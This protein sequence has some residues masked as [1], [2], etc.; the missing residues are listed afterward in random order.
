MSDIEISREDWLAAQRKAR[1]YKGGPSYWTWD[2]WCVWK[3]HVTN[4]YPHRDQA[5]AFEFAWDH[6]KRCVG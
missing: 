2:H 6:M 4:G 3:N 5:T 1:V